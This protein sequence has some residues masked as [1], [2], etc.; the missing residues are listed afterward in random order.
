MKLLPPASQTTDH[1]ESCPPTAGWF[2]QLVCRVRILWVTKM[3]GTILAMTLFFGLYFLLLKH[4]IFPLTTVPLTAVDRL[5]GFRPEALPLY[6]SLWIYV[7][8]APAFFKNCREL[9]SYSMA[10]VLLSAL[11]FGF[12][13]FWPTAV[14]KSEIDWAQHPAFLFLKTVDA[15]GNACPSMH[16]AFAVFTAVWFQWLLRGVGA[17]GLVLALNWLWCLGILYSTIATRQH[18]VIDI[19]CGAV[20]GAMVAVLFLRRRY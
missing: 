3:T 14:P 1:A 20:L 17:G 8:L 16:A 9:V 5:I 13:L 4:P 7:P 2:R 6:L 18:V 12:F 11:G 19:L 15:S 10:A